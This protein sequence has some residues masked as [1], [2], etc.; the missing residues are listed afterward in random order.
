MR[1]L[2]I[3]LT[4]L[5]TA[6]FLPTLAT[7]QD[8]TALPQERSW[9]T[10]TLIDVSPV[11]YDEQGRVDYVMTSMLTTLDV[12]SLIDLVSSRHAVDRGAREANPLMRWGMEHRP[13]DLV[14]KLASI[15]GSNYLFKKAWEDSENRLFG[16][17]VVGVT[18]AG[19][20]WIAC[21]NFWIT[22]RVPF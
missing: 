15:T 22:T 6:L 9:L 3:T 20:T 21:R 19:M 7:A 13:L 18:T 10:Q 16:Y 11:V 8:E 14:L 1:T 2:L 12:A 5:L 17:I 4:L